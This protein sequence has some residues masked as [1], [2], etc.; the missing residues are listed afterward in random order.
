M[1][2]FGIALPADGLLFAKRAS[3]R[4]LELEMGTAIVGG[5]IEYFAQFFG[6]RSALRPYLSALRCLDQSTVITG[7]D[8]LVAHMLAMNSTSSQIGLA[9]AS[10]EIQCNGKSLFYSHA[11]GLRLFLPFWLQ[12]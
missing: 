12:P 9:V 11:F 6:A 8:D 4:L 1:I 7:T 10:Q 3:Q 2:A 5:S